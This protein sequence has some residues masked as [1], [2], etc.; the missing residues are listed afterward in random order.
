MKISLIITTYNWKEALELVLCSAKSQSR[1]PDEIL[2][3]DDG[4]REDT[5]DLIESIAPKMPVPTHHVWH[6]DDGFRR[7]AILNRA[8]GQATGD[9]LIQVDGDVILHRHFVRDHE[10]FAKH[11]RFCAGSRTHL[12]EELTREVFHSKRIRFSA[13]E[14]GVKRPVNAL[15]IPWLAHLLYPETFEYKDIRGSN[16]AYW[17]DDAIAANGYNEDIAGWGRE[18]TEFVA[19]L[20]F[21]GI[22]RRKIKFAAKQYHLYHP[23]ASRSQLGDNDAILERTIR[24]RLTQCAHGIESLH[25]A[26]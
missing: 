3:A 18:D 26:S 25:P 22:R 15:R 11:G 5:R 17:R 14:H 12:S 1:L 13:W 23:E 10:S 21:N 6:E 4:S 20:T 7:S 8:I 19:R 9:Y 24:E 16:L 2:I